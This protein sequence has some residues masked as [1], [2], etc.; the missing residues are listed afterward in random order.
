M[1]RC[2]T[3]QILTIHWFEGVNTKKKKYRNKIGLQIF[4]RIP[5]LYTEE[6]KSEYLNYGFLEKT[7][8]AVI[9]FYKDTKDMVWSTE[10]D[11]GIFDIIAGVLQL[12]TLV[13]FV[14]IIYVY[15]ILRRST[16]KMK[17]NVFS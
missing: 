11:T 9:I 4:P 14:F 10:Y 17:E 8:T 1:N 16:Y 7:V 15:M 5:I 13:L 6:R 2:A 12:D 3:S